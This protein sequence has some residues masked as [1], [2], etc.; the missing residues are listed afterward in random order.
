M[1]RL[2]QDGKSSGQKMESRIAGVIVTDLM[3]FRDERGAVLHMLRCDAPFFERFGEIY[4]SK[5]HSGSIKAWKQHQEMTLNLA[6]PVGEIKVVLYDDRH[7]S[8]S[9]GVI[10]E[11]VLSEDNYKLVTVPPLIWTGFMG[12]A[13]ETSTLANLASLPH[14]SEEET[15]LDHFDERIPYR[16]R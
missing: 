15:N 6:V 4:F 10:E 1:Q 12:L 2:E 3:I 5:V 7:A 9:K 16:W 14:A 8:A 13:K 11:F